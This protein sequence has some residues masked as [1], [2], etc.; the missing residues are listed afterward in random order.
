[1]EC[2]RLQHT[3]DDE[4]TARRADFTVSIKAAQDTAKEHEGR[5]A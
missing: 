1:M 2:N 4:F 5:G 3:G